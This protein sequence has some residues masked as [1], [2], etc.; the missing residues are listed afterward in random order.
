MPAFEELLEIA[1]SSDVDDEVRI[2]GYGLD[3]V[4]T[5]YWPSQLPK[6]SADSSPESSY[7]QLLQDTLSNYSSK[8]SLWNSDHTAAFRRL[9]EHAARPGLARD[10]VVGLRDQD[11]KNMLTIMQLVSAPTSTHYL[12]LNDINSFAFS[13][14]TIQRKTTV[15]FDQLYT[16]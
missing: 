6:T 1:N 12:L 10:L 4:L 7:Q 5:R 3:L 16:Y 14:W 15:C 9:L 11:A 13:G 2:C 8:S